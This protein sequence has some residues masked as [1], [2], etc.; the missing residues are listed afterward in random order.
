MKGHF[1]K[2]LHSLPTWLLFASLGSAQ[3]PALLTL[4]NVPDARPIVADEP[5]REDFSAQQA[6]RYLDNASLN[7]QKSRKCA[8]CHTNMPY[9]MAR[10]ALGSAL[11]DSGEVRRF[12]EEY[13]LQRWEQGKQAPTGAYLPVVVGAALAFH[14]AQTSG[15]LSDTTR[16]TLDMMWA[17]QGDNGAWKW[18]KCGWA[19]MEIDD[20]YGVTLAALAVGIAPGNYAKTQ[21]AKAGMDKAREYLANNPAPSLHHR[22]MIAWASL[23]VDGLMEESERTEILADVLS[24]QLPDGGWATPA[25]LSDWKDFQ[26][27]DGKPQDPNTSDAYGTGLAIVVARELGTPATDERLQKGI[28]WLKHNQRESGKWFT[29]S[30]SKDSRHYFTNIGSAFAVLALQSCSQLPGRPFACGKNEQGAAVDADK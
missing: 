22:L 14:D 6:A 4:D 25:F 5:V 9:L 10:P 24:R 11:K 7:W 20:H 8:A 30:P 28:A 26:R 16:N 3:E 19:P 15:E 12:F 1:V 13:Y 27:K 17:T 23:R 21:A 29:R 2:V 18:I